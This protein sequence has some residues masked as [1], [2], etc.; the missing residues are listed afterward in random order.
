MPQSLAQVWIH[1]VFSTKHRRALLQSDTLRDEMHRYLSGISAKL[2]CPAVVVGGTEDHVHLLG[3][4]SRTITLADWVKELKRAS[5]LWAKTKGS[6]WSRF[7]WQA[8]YGAFSVSQSRHA[9]VQR[10]IKSQAEHHRRLSFQDELRELLRK[11]RI[12]FDEKYVWD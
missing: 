4:Q 7:Q 12:E 3:R 11:H 6:Q 5:S 1:I 2:D 8:G 9:D 10:Y